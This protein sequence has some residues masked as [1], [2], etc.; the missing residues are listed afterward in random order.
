MVDQTALDELRRE[1]DGIDDAI[2]DL[3]MRRTRVVEQI[4]VAK[5]AERERV[6][7]RPGREAVIV[8]RLVARH[9]GPLPHGVLVRIWR[10]MISS[11][12]RLQGAFAVSVYAPDDRRGGFWDIA[13]DHFGSFTPMAAVP[14]P[15]AAVRAV[16]D[17]TATVGVVPIPAEDDAD[18]WWPLLMSD[19]PKTPRVVARL[20]FC[21]RGN[22]RG[23]DSDALVLAQIPHEPTGDD[24]TLI[25]LEVEQDISRGRLSDLL[26]S[27]GL[28]PTTFCTWLGRAAV[29]GAY[30]MVE[31]ADFVNEEDPRLQGFA[32]RLEDS[33]VR[34]HTIGGYAVPMVMSGSARHS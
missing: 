28:N 19:D 12:T 13:R 8:R 33:L 30:H 6:F 21:G 17:G 14:S 16:T 27:S 18:P 3:L 2:H 25:G 9:T 4:R 11:L 15:V 32:E 26:K 7:L 20:P 10:E 22:A 24:R 1:I 23:D 5:G 34:L 29:G 31:V